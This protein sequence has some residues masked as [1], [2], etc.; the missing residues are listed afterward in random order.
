MR[1]VGDL[2]DVA[3]G[4]ERVEKAA[5][6]PVDARA[7]RIGAVQRVVGDREADPG[8][9]DPHDEAQEPHPR[10]RQEAADDQAVGAEIQRH[11]ARPS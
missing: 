8:H 6:Q 7:G 9:A 4:A 11:A 5:D 10:Q 1:I 3:V 2:P